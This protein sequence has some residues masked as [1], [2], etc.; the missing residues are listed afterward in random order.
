MK[1]MVTGGVASGK[2]T[3]A[4]ELARAWS[5]GKLFVATAEPLDEE[6]RARI[7]KHRRE[8]GESFR[9]VEEPLS[10]ER[11]AGENVVLDCVTMW[12]NNLLHYE[13]EAE[14]E[15]ILNAFLDG[16]GE[17][18]A[19]VTNEVGWGTIPENALARRFNRFLGA[20]N[21]LIASRMDE[22]YLLVSG[23]PLQIK[24]RGATP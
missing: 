7:A 19:I 20:A 24:S 15:R 17:R 8:R 14:W 3:F 5:G 21:R 18:A 16:L 4:L 6:M 23:V 13:K 22:V 1:V 9:T 2:S 11:H 12:M 10:I